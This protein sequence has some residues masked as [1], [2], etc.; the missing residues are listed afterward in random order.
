MATFSGFYEAAG[1]TVALDPQ[2]VATLFEAEPNINTAEVLGSVGE[3]FGGTGSAGRV[4]ILV[5]TIADTAWAAEVGEAGFD[6]TE[7]DL[8]YDVETGTI[9]ALPFTFLVGTERIEATADS[10]TVLTIVRGFGGTTPAAH[11]A[12]AACVFDV[13]AADLALAATAAGAKLSSGRPAA[14]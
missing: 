4:E 10:G 12:D 13:S 6:D 1:G 9:P 8:T 14:A 3:A 11:A 7:T 2:D 5:T